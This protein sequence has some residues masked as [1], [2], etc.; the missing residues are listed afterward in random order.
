P[1]TARERRLSVGLT[2]FFFQSRVGGG[3]FFVVPLFLSVCL[4]L[5]AL[6][7]GARLL[8]LSITLLAGAIGFPKLWPRVSPRLVVRCGLFSLFPGTIVLLAGLGPRAVGGAVPVP[9]RLFCRR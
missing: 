1:G 7:T 2:M 8:P 6:E 9:L 5:S 4:G 3:F